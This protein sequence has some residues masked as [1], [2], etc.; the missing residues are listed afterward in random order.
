MEFSDDLVARA[1]KEF[2]DKDGKEMNDGEAQ[3]ALRNLAGL[4]E[5]L[6][7]GAVED[8]RRKRRL[9]K[10]PEGFSLDGHYTCHVCHNTFGPDQNWYSR[11]G[12]T[13]RLCLQALKGGIVPEF[14]P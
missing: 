8:Q 7:K 6:Y 1:K 9:K 3:E 14:D 13:G 4:F 5:I 11:W 10:E 12:I 2:K